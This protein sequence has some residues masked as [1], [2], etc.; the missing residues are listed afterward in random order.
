[1][2]MKRGVLFLSLILIASVPL[3]SLAQEQEDPAEN[4]YG[5]WRRNFAAPSYGVA[6]F[7][8]QV[9]WEGLPN[10]SSSFNEGRFTVPAIDLRV[11]KGTNV[12][13]R[14]GFYTGVEVGALIYMPVSD[15]TFSDEVT[16]D[17]TMTGDG[18]WVDP[19][20]FT[21]EVYG[22]T[23][24]L[25]M[26]YGLR[27]DLGPSLFGLSG[28]FELGAGAALQSGGFRVMSDIAEQESH[29]ETVA[30]NLI[31]EPSL[32]G[33]IRLGRNFRLFIKVGAV[34]MPSIVQREK[35]I[36]TYVIDETN[37]GPNSPEDYRRYTLQGYKVDMDSVGGTLR[38]GFSLNF[39]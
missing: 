1:M 20:D 31:V 36:D 7:G 27:I 21:V 34:V 38:L 33:A 19:Y 18:T 8:A 16:I 28:G 22:G 24:F 30:L 14:G 3:V 17:D 9:H 39:N 25:M 11:F 5:L 23:V 13:R 37:A 4:N 2:D 6:V 12:S 29:S 35:Q 15:E 26:K 10:T 32:E